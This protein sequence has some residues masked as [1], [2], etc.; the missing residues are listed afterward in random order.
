M[1]NGIIKNDKD[2]IISINNINNIYIREYENEIGLLTPYQADRLNSYL[3]D[4]SEEMIIEAIHI[5]SRMNKKS[6]SYIEAIL[7]NWISNGYKVPGDIKKRED[8]QTSIDMNS[9]N[10]LYEN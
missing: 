6:L 2:N 10:E 4:L 1:I 8:K 3:E 9:L 5:A 7:K